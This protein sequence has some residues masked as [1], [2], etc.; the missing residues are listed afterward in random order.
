MSCQVFRP[1]LE[2]IAM[3]AVFLTITK[4]SINLLVNLH[5]TERVKIVVEQCETASE[6]LGTAVEQIS[7]HV[8][9]IRKGVAKAGEFVV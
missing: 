6:N 5:D 7:H 9:G 1:E 3:T 4:Q 8:E 2:Y